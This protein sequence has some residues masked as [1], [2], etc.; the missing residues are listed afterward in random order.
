M[1]MMLRR[2]RIKADE[3]PKEVIP[4]AIAPVKKF[5]KPK[6]KS[7]KEPEPEQMEMVLEEQPEE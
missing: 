3:S 4:E 1:G 5:K 7:V 6:A 2:H